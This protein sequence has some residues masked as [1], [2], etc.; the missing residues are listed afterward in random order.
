MTSA[1]DQ[2]LN[3]PPYGL[4]AEVKTAA[5]LAAVR[6][7]IAHHAEHCPPYARW[8]RRR[9]FDPRDPI[10]RL[11]DVPF[12]PVGIFKRLFLSSV[13]E[14]QV[15]RVLTSSG[16][17]S[18]VPS[19]IPLDQTT[20]NRQMKALGAILA[21]RLGG[22]RRPYLI[23]D[24][25]NE[26]SLVADRELSARVAGMRGY[27]M[28][29]TEQEYV[30]LRDGDH[31]LFDRDKLLAAV[32]RWTAEGKPFCLLGYTY[33]L[34]EYVVRPLREQGVRIELPPST[35][36]IH[37]G[38]WKKLKQQAVTKPELTR[39]TSEVFGLPAGSIVDIY[40]FT[41]QLGVVYPDDRDGVKRSPTYAE[42][43][44]RDPRTLE[45][46]PDGTVG[47][48]EFI[49]PLPHSYPGIAVL[50]DDM[51]RIV[52]RDLGSDDRQG[53]GFEVVGRAEQA[54]VRGCGD[55]LPNQ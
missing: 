30:L 53:T 11:A 46:V 20:R 41:E 25:Q 10:H 31:L 36:V 12:L 16:T 49:C 43:L 23:L 48:L 55:T 54:E 52:T 8:L 47:L 7:Q 37:F 9:G 4:T 29:A 27:L 34:Y 5:L 18:Q 35:F 3:L 26:S 45:L 13:A 40:G 15:V 21:H 1:T 42:V 33:M 32:R 2:L 17:S 19:R 39:H 14:S 50:L 24:A 28:A 51:G 6:E 44:V 22:Q 38:G